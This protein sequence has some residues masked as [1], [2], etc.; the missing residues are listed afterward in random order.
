VVVLP[1]PFD[2]LSRA[3]R[4]PA[5]IVATP[6]GFSPVV[7]QITSQ[8]IRDPYA[9]LLTAADFASGAVHKDSYIRTN[10]LFTANPARILYHAG[11]VTAAKMQEVTDRLVYLFTN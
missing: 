4:R 6:P 8:T 1:F 2:D 3:K 5:L 9:V 7:A 10:I 11:R